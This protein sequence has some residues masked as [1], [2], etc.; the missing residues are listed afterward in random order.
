MTDQAV[1]V[2]GVSGSGKSTVGRLL[3]RRLGWPFLD[4]DD[5]HPAAN[6]ARMTA[7]IP[8]ADADREPWLRSIADWLARGHADGEPAI[9]ACSALKRRYRDQLRA[10]AP[11]LRVV[12]LAA[13]PDVLRQRVAHRPGHF[14]PVRLFENQLRDLEVPGPDEAPIVVHANNLPEKIVD[15][16]VLTL[17]S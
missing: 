8:L 12:Y 7:G 4:A 16:L 3:A 1:L 13:E 17:R 10:A 5:L 9:L 11:G 14:F 2:M 6:I 15:S